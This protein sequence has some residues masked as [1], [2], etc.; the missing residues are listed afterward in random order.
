M[1]RRAELIR[2]AEQ[3]RDEREAARTAVESIRDRLPL[4][5][6]DAEF[7]EAW[8]T[9]G[10]VRELVTAA[11]G[12]LEQD[13]VKSRELAQMAV[14]VAGMI[15]S[16]RYPA[17]VFAQAEAEAWR[18]VGTAHRYL[19]AFD[20]ALR[21]FDA[22]ERS[23]NRAGSFAHERAV[24]D[25]ARAIA[26]SA[27][28][29]QEDAIRALTNAGKVF[30]EYGDERRLAQ[31]TVVRG[32]THH[33]RAEYKQARISFEDALRRVRNLDDLH[34]LAAVHM[35]LGNTLGHLG[36]LSAA[37]GHLQQAHDLLVALELPLEIA[38]ADLVL[39]RILLRQ[40]EYDKAKPIL[41][42]VRE[43]FLERAMIEEAG[44]AALDLVEIHIAHNERPEAIALTE[45]IIGQFTEAG[46]SNHALTALAYLRDLLRTDAPAHRPIEHVRAYLDQLRKEPAR[47][48]LPLPE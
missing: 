40:S 14:T 28:N 24:L 1:N 46:L 42:S 38:R 10:V 8:R 23:L 3:L 43:R 20:A 6:A 47:A 34:T 15:A 21:A 29:R 5:W 19:S 41:E 37:A 7:P 45:T 44:H 9:L 12:L 35:N 36:E 17:P 18:M 30:E 11:D 2:V 4:V 22:A 27:M 32:M 31:C 26:F 48:F 33:R 16:D 39:A 25:F 13:P